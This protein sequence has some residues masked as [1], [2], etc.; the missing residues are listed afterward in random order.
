MAVG[1]AGISTGADWS[2]MISQL[3]QIESKSLYRLQSRDSELD[4][5][6]SDY[7]LVKSAIDTFQS[8]VDALREALVN[9]IIHRDYS[10]KGAGIS[11][12][13]YD[14]RIEIVNPGGFPQGLTQR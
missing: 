9:A 6:I 2:S 14:D 1:F 8:K 3:V 4:R 12:D 13:V 7:G 10:F 11:V 5:Q